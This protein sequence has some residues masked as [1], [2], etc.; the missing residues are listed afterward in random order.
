V[1]FGVELWNSERLCLLTWLSCGYFGI[2]SFSFARLGE[3]KDWAR[4]NN[5]DPGGE[6]RSYRAAL[7]KVSSE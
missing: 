3:E 6:Y 5:Q 7:P 1:A 4:R 2:F